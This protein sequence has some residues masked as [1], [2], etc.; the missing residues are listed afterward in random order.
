MGGVIIKNR[1]NDLFDYIDNVNEEN[2]IIVKKQN[3]T[4]SLFINILAITLLVSGGYGIK[5][6]LDQQRDIEE[7]KIRQQELLASQQ[8]QAEAIKQKQEEEKRNEENKVNKYRDFTKLKQKNSDTVGWLIVPG[9]T[10][11][12]PI[13]KTKNNSYYLTH[14][15]DKKYNSM[16]W[17]FADYHNKF[18]DLSTNTIIYGHTYKRT[19]MFS[20]LKNV[21]ENSWLDNEQ[22]HTITFDTEKERLKFKVFSVYTIEKTDD[23]LYIDFASENA[24]QKYLNKEIKRSIK[25][26][27][28]TPTTKDKIITLSTCYYDAN[29]RLVVHGVVEESL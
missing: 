19:S 1:F 18:P 13:V 15:F 22:K 9:T 20:N 27:D 8:R 11:N 3:K 23:Y 24:Y 2:T 17:V 10:I 16:G 12:M 7:S 21:L 28:V 4:L 5:Y 6:T 29:Q 14:N 26:F 25:K